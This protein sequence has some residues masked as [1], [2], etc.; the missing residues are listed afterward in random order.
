MADDDAP[1]SSPTSFDPF[2]PEQ[3]STSQAL[4]GTALV[5]DPDRTQ[6]TWLLALGTAALV[7]VVA[8]GAWL[9]L[10]GRQRAED[11]A[12]ASPSPTAPAHTTPPTPSA[13]PSPTPSPTPTPSPSPTP[14][15]DHPFPAPA[16]ALEMSDF[17]APSGNISC[18]LGAE[19]TVCT[20]AA[21]SF[22]PT[23]D[24]CDATPDAPFTVRLRVD[25]TVT[26]D[27]ASEFIPSGAQLDY[28]S[29]ASS[30]DFACTST[31]SGVDCWSQVTGTGIMISRQDA[32][33]T[34]R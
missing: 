25:G 3:E 5:Q 28:G 21:H 12:Q 31:E 26:S 13:S 23:G 11:L 30:G 29:A 17:S 22:V 9:V 27:C 4:S 10:S 7:V 2:A 24:Q 20:I 19:E 1:A 18:F 8:L 6:R 15:P 32:Q 33:V 34:S 16:N 14:T